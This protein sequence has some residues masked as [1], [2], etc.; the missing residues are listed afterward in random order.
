M[1]KTIFGFLWQLGKV[2]FQASAQHNSPEMVKA[3]VLQSVQDHRDAL[4][5]INKTLQDPTASPNEHADALEKLR[6]QDS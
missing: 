4:S 2:W 5:T 1:I 6:R 3:K